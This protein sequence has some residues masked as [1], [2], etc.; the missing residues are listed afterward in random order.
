MRYVFSRLWFNVNLFSSIHRDSVL[1]ETVLYICMH[2]S[3]ID[4]HVCDQVK[5]W[6]QIECGESVAMCCAYERKSFQSWKSKKRKHESIEDECHHNRV[7]CR[8]CSCCHLN[9]DLW[10]YSQIINCEIECEMW[11]CLFTF[12]HFRFAWL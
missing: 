2:S 3:Y 11:K 6:M 7:R 10:T 1:L 8:R 4:T 9:L 5:C 12:I